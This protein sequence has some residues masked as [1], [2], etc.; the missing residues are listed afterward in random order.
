MT[1]ALGTRDR[2][3][4]RRAL[5]NRPFFLLWLSQL[6]SQSGDFVFDV[7]LLWLVLEVTGSV[8]AVGVVVAIIAL[9]GVVL[10]PFLGS[11]WT[12]GIDERSSSRPMRPKGWWWPLSPAWSWP[13]RLASPSFS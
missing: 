2:P 10:G 7:A 8:F 6:I 13:M 4:Y 9:P 12:D 5:G 1:V 3:S 11:T